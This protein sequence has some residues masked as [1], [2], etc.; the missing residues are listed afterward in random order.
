MAG[1]GSETGGQISSQNTICQTITKTT[2]NVSILKTSLM[3]KLI[4]F[5]EFEGVSILENL[6]IDCSA[7]INSIHYKIQVNESPYHTDFNYFGH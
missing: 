5:V 6:L 3:L 7:Q 2:R 4:S 1:E